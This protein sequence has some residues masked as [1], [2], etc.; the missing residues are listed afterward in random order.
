MEVLESVLSGV[1]FLEGLR[2][3]E[4][5][6]VARKLSIVTLAAKDVTTPEIQASIKQ[7]ETKAVASG[8]F[9]APVDVTVS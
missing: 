7:L 9:N 1:P 8:H 4:I 3:D 5:A 2:P 6:R